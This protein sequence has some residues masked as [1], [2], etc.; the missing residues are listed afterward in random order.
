MK[1]EVYYILVGLGILYLASSIPKNVDASQQERGGA[2]THL[3]AARVIQLPDTYPRNKVP[4]LS[5]LAVHPEKGLLAAAGDDHLVRIWSLSD[6]KMVRPLFGHQDWVRTVLFAEAGGR[7]VSAGDDGNLLFWDDY[8]AENTGKPSNTPLRNGHPIYSAALS[9]DGSLL[10]FGGWAD[11]LLVVD[12]RSGRKLRELDAPGSDI[13]SVVFSPDGGSLAA[14]GRSGRIR[15]WSMPSGERRHDLVG[16]GVRVWDM[17]Y[18]LDGKW[19]ASSGEEHFVRLWDAKTGKP[20]PILDYRPGTGSALAFCGNSWLAVGGSDNS[21]RLWD[22]ENL[23]QPFELEG[24]T[25]TITRLVWDSGSS[26]LYSASYDTTIRVWSL[27]KAIT[28]DAVISRRP[29]K[30]AV[31]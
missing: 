12:A 25:G 29:D 15:V 3:T 13:R 21:I 20:G 9:A 8:L 11:R 7:L 2:P 18:S 16:H 17:A 30:T 1:R 4:V 10:V 19:L 23:T 5:A 31:R 26:T 27:Q 22:V 24:H 6:G 28:S 14:A